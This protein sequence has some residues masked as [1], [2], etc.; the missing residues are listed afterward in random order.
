MAVCVQT[1]L[2]AVQVVPKLAFPLSHYID[3]CRLVAKSCLILQTHGLYP[4][5][6]FP[7]RKWVPFPS[8]GDLPGQGSELRSPSLA[9][10]FMTEPR[11]N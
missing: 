9:G 3:C 10:F 4:A 8:P 11:G 6:D 1:S 7:G 2:L 5:R